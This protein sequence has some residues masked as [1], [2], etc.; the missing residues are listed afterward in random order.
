MNIKSKKWEKFKI[1]HEE[2]TH[3]GKIYVLVVQE[4][5]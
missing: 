1:E 5:Q 2:F 4:A 3:F